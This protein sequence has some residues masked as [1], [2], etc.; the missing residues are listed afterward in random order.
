VPTD[1]L[2]SSFRSPA[3]N[4][5][6]AAIGYSLGVFSLVRLGWMETHLV[7]PMTQWQ[8]RTAAAAFGAPALP[9][10]VGLACSGADA[11]ALC[12]GAI[13]AYPATWK[14]RLVGTAVGFALIMVLNSVRIGTLGRA[15]ASPLLFDTLHVYVWPAVLILAIAGYVFVWM[16]RANARLPAASGA[17]TPVATSTGMTSRFVVWAV[18]FVALFVATSP[19]YLRSTTVLAVAAFIARSAAGALGLVG[20]EATTAGNI[21]QTSRGAFEVTQ[22]CI[23]TPVIPVYFAIV[24]T[25]VSQWRWRALGFAAAAPVFV[26]LGIV[27]L[28]LVALPAAVIGSPLFLIHAFYQFLLAAL[29]VFGAAAWRRGADAGRVA[30]IGCLAGAASAYLL[31]PAYAGILSLFGIDVPFNDAQGAM[32]SLPSFQTGLYIALSIALMTVL[33]WQAFAGGLA[34]LVVVQGTAFIALHVV[35]RV[36]DLEPHIRDVRAWAIAAPLAIVTL[37]AMLHERPGD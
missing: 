5:V 19:L 8:G 10:D 14:R 2:H 33:T 20:I 6:I 30:L 22:E 9:I 34:A 35:S 7:L 15:A 31:G 36:S 12:A 16:R 1:M 32:A 37:G 27:R 29:V 11:F 28:L 13:L 18:V 23:A 26:A 25:A 24:M 3:S 4:F 21:L 17:D